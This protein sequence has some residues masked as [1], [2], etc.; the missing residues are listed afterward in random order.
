MTRMHRIP[1]PELMNDPAQAQAYAQA[2]F[3]EPN[4]LFVDT[5]AARFPAFSGGLVVDLGCGPA[6]IAVRLA[7][8]FPACRVVALDGAPRM[9]ALADGLVAAARL[10]DRVVTSVCRFGQD[11]VP[12]ALAAAADA[13][14]S[15]SLLHHLHNPQELWRWVRACARPG[16]AVLVMDLLRPVD[17]AAARGLVEC[18]AADEAEVLKADFYRSLLAAYRLEEVVRQLQRA[19]LADFEVAQISDRHLL[20]CGM[21]P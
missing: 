12:A 8:R 2:D 1:E 10:Q 20:V 16:A 11:P 18:H 3:S 17:V 4:G 13:V 14:V 6:D 5:F 9:L 21:A 7:R 15:N 19:D